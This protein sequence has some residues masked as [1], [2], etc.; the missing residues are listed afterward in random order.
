M[1]VSVVGAIGAGKSELIKALQKKIGIQAILE[2]VDDWH[3]ILELFYEN[4][5]QYAFEFQMR[6]FDDHVSSILDAIDNDSDSNN[7]KRNI[8]VERSMYCAKIFWDMQKDLVSASQYELYNRMWMKWDSLIP[9]YSYYIFLDTNNIDALLERIRSRNRDGECGISNDYE[10]R[11][12]EKHKN[13]YTKQRFNDKL[14][15]LDALDTIEC[16][17]NKIKNLFK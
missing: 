8:I 13:F 10:R 9:D 6:V 14:I 7:D 4:P 11:L 1:I 16:N 5:S 17:V 3:D 2:P 15:I 12:I